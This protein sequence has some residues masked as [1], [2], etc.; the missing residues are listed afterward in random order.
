MSSYPRPTPVERLFEYMMPEPNS[1]CWL[2]M[3]KTS[4]GY[5]I[6]GLAN[7]KRMAA[8]KF[9][10]ELV[11]GK[12]PDNLVLDHLCR[13]RCCVNPDHLEPV[14]NKENILRGVSVS[15]VYAKRSHCKSGHE[16]TAENTAWS[17]GRDSE[18]RGRQCRACWR[19]KARRRYHQK[20]DALLA[21]MGRVP[22]ALPVPDL[23]DNKLTPAG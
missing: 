17:K 10:W 5:G 16:Y 1:G 4:N 14:T 2:W 12:V 13:V 9:S 18:T 7:R 3:G 23:K 21:F 22:A 11:H 20:A 19:E 6:I 15:A 8:H